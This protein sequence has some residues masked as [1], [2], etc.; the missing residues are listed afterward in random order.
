MFLQADS[1]S[2]S[3]HDNPKSWEKQCMPLKS[4]TPNIIIN[5]LQ[6][7]YIGFTIHIKYPKAA[8]L[9]NSEQREFALIL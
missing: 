2:F 6:M 8:D 3:D 5:V 4:E 7:E 9:W 1:S